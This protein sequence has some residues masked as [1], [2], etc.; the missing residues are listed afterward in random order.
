M[1]LLAT[2]GYLQPGGYEKLEG[3]TFM[4]EPST[5]GIRGRGS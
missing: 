3:Q 4:A 2:M 1:A 5:G